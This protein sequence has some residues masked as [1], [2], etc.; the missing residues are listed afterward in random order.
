MEIRANDCEPGSA[1]QADV[2]WCEGPNEVR[3]RG[4]YH[5]ELVEELRTKNADICG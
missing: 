4:R 2:C 1:N 3:A 5:P